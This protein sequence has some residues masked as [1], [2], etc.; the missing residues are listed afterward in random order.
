MPTVSAFRP[1]VRSVPVLPWLALLLL[2]A[3]PGA[4]AAAVLRGTVRVPEAPREEPAFQPY[5][6][7]ANAMVC[8]PR[9][10]RGAPTDAVVWL[11]GVP[12]TADSALPA[13]P[14]PRLSQKD[15]SFQPRVVAVAVGGE[16]DFPNLDPIYHNVFSVSPVRRFDLGKYPKGQSRTVKFSKPGLV[17]VYCDIHSDMAAFVVVTPGRAIARPRSDG[18]WE[19]PDLPPGRYTLV[20][21]HPD[22]TGGRRDVDLAA[23][24]GTPLELVFTP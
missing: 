3:T 18:G 7:Q 9:V 4:P 14:R 12:A 22:F 16:V 23:G 20:W 10:S 24:G 13:P 8:K 19:L 15:Q 5:P 1:H 21:W 6:G 2:L 11:E 17:N